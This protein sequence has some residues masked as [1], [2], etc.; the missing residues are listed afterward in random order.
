MYYYYYGQGTAVPTPGINY[1]PIRSRP[2]TD[3][4]VL[5]PP[6][7]KYDPEFLRNA[8]LMPLHPNRSHHHRAISPNSDSE[9]TNNANAEDEVMPCLKAMSVENVNEIL[10]ES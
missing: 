2:Q 3:S 9:S 7:C 4:A 5:C 8:P 1:T 10:N 6:D